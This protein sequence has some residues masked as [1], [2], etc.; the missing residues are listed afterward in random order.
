M[1]GDIYYIR[2]APIVLQYT[3]KAEDIYQHL[4]MGEPFSCIGMDFEMNVSKKGNCC[5]LIFQDYLTKWPEVLAVP[6]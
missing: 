5:T 1:K 2:S 6:D 3:D 4:S